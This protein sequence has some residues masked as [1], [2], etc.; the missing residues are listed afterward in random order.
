MAK[1]CQIVETLKYLENLYRAIPSDKTNKERKA[2]ALALFT[3]F[4]QN[5]AQI[6]QNATYL[7]VPVE[8]VQSK[9]PQP[10]TT[11]TGSTATKPM[12]ET[13]LTG[14]KAF[15][16]KIIGFVGAQKSFEI[17]KDA[18]F[19]LRF[20]K[21]PTGDLARYD[22]YGNR[23]TRITYPD[24]DAVLNNKGMLMNLMNTLRHKNLDETRKVVKQYQKDMDFN[25]V[26]I[27][28]HIHAGAM[29]FMH[30]NPHDSKTV[31]VQNLYKKMLKKAK[32]DPKLDN[33]QNGYWKENVD[34]FLAVALSNVEMI[35]YLNTQPATGF[36]SLFHKLVDAL[37]KM[38][39][40]KMGSENEALLNIFVRMTEN[41]EDEM[42]PAWEDTPAP[43]EADVPA[44]P[45]VAAEES[46]LEPYKITESMSTNQGQ[47]A[48]INKMKEWFTGGKGDTFLLQGRGGTG[49]TTVIN[50]LL[51]ELGVRP[52]DVVFAAPTNKAVKVL[53][54]ANRGSAYEQSSHH[55][56]AQL[57]GVKPQFDQS[58]NQIFKTDPYATRPSLGKVLVIDEASMLHS[59]NYEGI[60]DDA[61]SRGTK[62]IFMGDNAQLPPIKDKN[63]PTKSVVFEQNKDTNAHL[64]ELMRQGKQS[65]IITFTDRLIDWVNKLESKLERK[66]AP[67]KVKNE[68]RE[69]LWDGN[70][71]TSFD[72]KINEGVILVSEDFESLLPNFIKDY[73]KA[74]T[75]TKYINYNRF[76]HQTTLAHVNMIR[77]YLYGDKASEERFIS[78]EPLMVNG[79]YEYDVDTDESKRVDNGEE[80][81]VVSSQVVEKNIYYKVGQHARSTDGKIKVYQI[82]AKNNVDGEEITFNKPMTKSDVDKL[83]AN[84]RAVLQREGKNPAGAF[85]IKSVLASEVAHGYIINSHRAQ[86]STYDTVYMDFGNISGQ[87]MADINS[88]VKSMY[89]AASRPRKK[90]VVIDNRA[91]AGNQI[92]NASPI[93]QIESINEVK[94]QNKGEQADILDNVDK[95]ASKGL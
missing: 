46:T 49:K 44:K 86:G 37:A 60:I 73:K 16:K 6:Q 68:F 52:S 5:R 38:V 42:I 66:V 81:T 14:Y 32:T 26:Q 29:L 87:G 67:H 27:H 13:R 31:Y 79:P 36:T 89:V 56:V 59:S 82:V 54:K 62:V 70:D 65:P 12:A 28:E 18:N 47:T 24:F 45:E 53:A 76:D 4:N 77:E 69:E 61:R 11:T 39:N 91:N 43:P 83:I 74:P 22:Y 92:V 25:M 8:N 23:P 15:A 30:Q 48:A 75:A 7:G 21:D 71:L 51:K 50:V 40:I 85:M 78:G 80:F 63:A 34:E 3:Q 10:P 1:S 72:N 55:T 58:G 33:I 94:T 64:T 41:T 2:V 93:Q 90:L 95:C 57:L 84:E 20:I 35:K 9:V 19:T 17:V 88:I